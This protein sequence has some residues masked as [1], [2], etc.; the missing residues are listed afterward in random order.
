MIPTY[1]PATPWSHIRS[2]CYSA[3]DDVVQDEAMLSA[4]PGNASNAFFVERLQAGA[5]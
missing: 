1:R 4:V 3:P 2:A 5:S